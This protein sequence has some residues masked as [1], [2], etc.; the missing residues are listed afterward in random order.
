MTQPAK[1]HEKFNAGQ[2]PRPLPSRQSHDALGSDRICEKLIVLHISADSAC[3][4]AGFDTC[5]ASCSRERFLEHC[6]PM[7][8]CA[9]AFDENLRINLWVPRTVAKKAARAN[10]CPCVARRIERH[11]FARIEIASVYAALMHIARMRVQ[12]AITDCGKFAL[13]RRKSMHLHR[14]DA[15][16][17]TRFLL[18]Y[19]FQ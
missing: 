4:D 10:D 17:D 16:S 12:A 18:D 9:H 5:A 19:F 7:R 13:A 2:A 11:G 8:A 3:R 14:C 1:R 15:Q 6:P